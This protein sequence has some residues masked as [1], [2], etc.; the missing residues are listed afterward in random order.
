MECDQITARA[1]RGDGS[2]N[3]GGGIEVNGTLTA[4]GAI[5][6]TGGDANSGSGFPGGTTP[7]TLELT[8]TGG[9]ADIPYLNETAK[10]V[11]PRQRIYIKADDPPEGQRFARWE[12]TPE[13]LASLL[14]DIDSE[15]ARPRQKQLHF[16]GLV[17]TG[18]RQVRLY[19]AGGD[20]QGGGGLCTG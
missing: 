6:A 15:P 13:E 7:Y 14:G 3:G 16:R 11:L 19:H 12:V 2:G 20:G 5:K 18:R 8:V 1:G 10:T 4:T 9:T 17:H